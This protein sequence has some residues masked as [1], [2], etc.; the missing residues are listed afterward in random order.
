MTK[1]FYKTLRYTVKVFEIVFFF[2]AAFFEMAGERC[3]E[4]ADWCDQMTDK[5]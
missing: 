1:Y 5:I 2:L 4:C 3:R